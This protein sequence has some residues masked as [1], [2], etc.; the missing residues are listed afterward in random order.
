M[1]SRV[2]RFRVT[3]MDLEQLQAAAAEVGVPLSTLVRE[4]VALYLADL[5][6]EP[7][8]TFPVNTPTPCPTPRPRAS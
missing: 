7:V 2:L 6:D 1:A 4:A 8:P 5:Y 3:V